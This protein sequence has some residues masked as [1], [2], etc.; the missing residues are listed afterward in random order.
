MIS[1]WF[2]IFP[3][4]PAQYFQR[5]LLSNLLQP[6][7][8]SLEGF[9]ELDG[10]FVIVTSQPFIVGRN[11]TLQEIRAYMNQRGFV[12]LCE[13]GTSLKSLRYRL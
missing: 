3:A 13:D 12:K 5:L 8:N 2:A 4:T 11:A 10:R 6:G 7:L 9:C 1:Y